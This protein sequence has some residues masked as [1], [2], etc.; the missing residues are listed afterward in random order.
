MNVEKV[1][2][3]MLKVR[4]MPRSVHFYSEILRLEIIYG[5]HRQ[6]NTAPTRV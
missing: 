4:N 5:G 1:S 2:A 3:I 6:D